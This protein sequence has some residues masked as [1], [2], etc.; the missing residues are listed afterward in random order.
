VADELG[1][2]AIAFPSLGTGIYGN[3]LVPSARIA[4]GTVIDYLRAGSHIEEVT[5]VLFSEHDLSVYEQA[6]DL[7]ISKSGDT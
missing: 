2:R 3:P 4:L 5:F 6:L 7:L 1:D